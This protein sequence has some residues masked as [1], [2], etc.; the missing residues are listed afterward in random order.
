MAIDLLSKMSNCIYS[1]G[2]GRIRFAYF[3]CDNKRQ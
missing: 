1:F 2:L 3:K